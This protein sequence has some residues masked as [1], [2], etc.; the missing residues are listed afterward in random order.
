MT[1]SVD[2]LA[3]HHQ[4]KTKDITMPLTFIR[5]VALGDPLRNRAVR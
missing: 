1:A 4:V 5:V 2:G 3:P